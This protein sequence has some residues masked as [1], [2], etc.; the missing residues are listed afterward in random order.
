MLLPLSVALALS[1]ASPTGPGPA[2]R[3]DGP[4]DAVSRAWS[5]R[6]ATATKRLG[7]KGLDACDRAVE[8]A[9]AS[10][11]VKSNGTDRTWFLTVEVGG[12]QMLVGWAYEGTQLKDFVV[13]AL[14]PRWFLRKPAG[15]RVLTVLVST[16]ECALDLCPDDPLADAPCGK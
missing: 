16:S 8:Q 12:Q 4:E 1:I 11:K 14:P 5:L 7:G 9:F 15:S 10:A 3:R 2:P 13:G 6:A